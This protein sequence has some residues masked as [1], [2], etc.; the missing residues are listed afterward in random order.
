LLSRV[1]EDDVLE[2][3][4]FNYLFEAVSSELFIHSFCSSEQTEST[5]AD[6]S[7][8]LCLISIKD[9]SLLDMETLCGPLSSESLRIEIEDWLLKLFLELGNDYSPFW[10]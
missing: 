1:L 2:R 8:N 4:F 10:N 3:L 9:L 6:I 7:C 5:V